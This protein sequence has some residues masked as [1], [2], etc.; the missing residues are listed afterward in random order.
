MCKFLA[1]DRDGKVMDLINEIKKRGIKPIVTPG[2]EISM[3][4]SVDNHKDVKLYIGQEVDR[5]TLITKLN[6]VL[7]DYEELLASRR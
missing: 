7:A 1:N 4:F 6:L 5:D 2:N 3:S